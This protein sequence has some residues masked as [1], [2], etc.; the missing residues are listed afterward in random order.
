MKNPSPHELLVDYYTQFMDLYERFLTF[1]GLLLRLITTCLITT[2]NVQLWHK[3][4]IS[5]KRVENWL[6]MAT[7]KYTVLLCMAYLLFVAVVPQV[8]QSY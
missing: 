5:D 3:I 6:L 1:A 8:P 2:F 4:V 7:P